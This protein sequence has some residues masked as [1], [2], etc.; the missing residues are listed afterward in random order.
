MTSSNTVLSMIANTINLT[1]VI[2]YQTQSVTTGTGVRFDI[3]RVTDNL[4]QIHIKRPNSY[5]RGL[6]TIIPLEQFKN[7]IR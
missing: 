6:Y 5:Y 1:K 2:N 4:I 3:N 7:F